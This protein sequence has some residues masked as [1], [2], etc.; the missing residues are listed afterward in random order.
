MLNTISGND[1]RRNIR[2]LLEHT[3]ASRD[4]ELERNGAPAY[5]D[6]DAWTVTVLNTWKSPET[7]AEYPSGWRITIP[8]WNLEFDVFPLAESQE[9]VS[10]LVAD[11]FYWEG[12]VGIQARDGT[13][14]GRGFVELTGYGEGSRPAL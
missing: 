12:A 3:P 8:T 10:D 7:A 1:H 5:P 4:N 6:G 14:I 13:T 11:L 9:N 2:S